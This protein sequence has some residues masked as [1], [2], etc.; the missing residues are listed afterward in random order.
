MDPFQHGAN[1]W[2]SRDQQ[3]DGKKMHQ[4]RI[5]DLHFTL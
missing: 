1:D 3:A 4:F 5:Q 2:K